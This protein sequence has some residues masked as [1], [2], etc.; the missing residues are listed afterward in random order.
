MTQNSDEIVK[1][2]Q[3][4]VD[5]GINKKVLNIKDFVLHRGELAA[6]I[7]P[8]GAGKST[9][10]QTVNLLH[11]WQGELQLFG[12][13]SRCADKTMLRRRAAMVFQEMLLFHDSVFNNVAAPLKFRK[14]APNQIKELVYHG[15][16][17][18]R[19]DHLSQRSAR[20]L[21]GGEMQR[22]C[23]ARALVSE[24]ELLLLD[25]PFAA[26]DGV[27]RMELIERI[28]QVAK[29]QNITVILVSHNFTD[30]LHFA[31]RAVALFDGSIIQDARP[32]LLMRRPVDQQVARLVGMD[33]I[34][35]CSYE[36]DQGKKFIALTCG[37]RFLCPERVSGP[38][39]ACCLPGDAFQLY[40][41]SFASQP[42]QWVLVEG[43]V[44]Q[45]VPGIGTYCLQVSV[46][47]QTLC[48]R[49]PRSEVQDMMARQARIKLAFK[50][51]EAH[52]V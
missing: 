19:C 4:T 17:S 38:I 45:V 1:M 27:T 11:R 9:F 32:E 34:I 52:I 48:V 42:A 23:I 37:I 15:L 26:L 51:S 28:R 5:R 49:L 31:E 22:V 39:T 24:P 3:L 36:Q 33:N 30:V 20:T 50:S 7:G 35:P 25:E 46:G 29:M 21:S 40:R 6:I 10:L 18:F 13:D 14:M 47:G 44:E 43:L 12:H 2:R 8:N 41:E 16:A